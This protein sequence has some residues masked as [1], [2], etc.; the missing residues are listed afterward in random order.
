[1]GCMTK[2][3]PA[4]YRTTN[5]PSYNAA[6]RQRGSLLI[7]CPAAHARMCKRVAGQGDDLA[8]AA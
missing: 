5:W 8:C 4:R 3:S 6:L 1:M 2:P 7:H